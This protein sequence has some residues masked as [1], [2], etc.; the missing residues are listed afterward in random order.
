M[1]TALANNL[2]FTIWPVLQIAY[3]Y[4]RTGYDAV[5]FFSS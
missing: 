5:H 3:E 4:Y 2:T 1:F